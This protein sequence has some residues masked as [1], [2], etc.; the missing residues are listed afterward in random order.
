MRAFF[1]TMD[2]FL[3]KIKFPLISL[4]GLIILFVLA[5][6]DIKIWVVWVCLSPTIFIIF[7]ICL[8]AILNRE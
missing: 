8:R 6:F 4:A 2:A 5:F 3:N 7:Y 1:E